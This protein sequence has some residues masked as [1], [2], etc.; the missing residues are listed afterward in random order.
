[1]GVGF[2]S[3]HYFNMKKTICLFLSLFLVV[4]TIL[5]AMAAFSDVSGS[6]P[7]KTAIEYLQT[8][9]VL[10]GYEDGTFRPDFSVN[11]AELVKIVVAGQGINPDANTHKNCFSDVGTEWFAPYI[12]YAKAQGWIQGDRKAHV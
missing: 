4:N 6:N 1:M 8:H 12:C 5:P 2:L 11:R 9:N 3:F 7:H 10:Q